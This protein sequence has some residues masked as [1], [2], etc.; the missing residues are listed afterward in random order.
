MSTRLAK[1]IIKTFC[2]SPKTRQCHQYL[3]IDCAI[4]LPLMAHA[5]SYG[6]MYVPRLLMQGIEAILRLG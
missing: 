5:T 1:V 4:V 3:D 2:S 6:P